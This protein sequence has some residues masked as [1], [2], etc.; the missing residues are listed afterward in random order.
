MMKYSGLTGWVPVVA[1]VLGL[2]VAAFASGGEGGLE[3]RVIWVMVGW[4][5]WGLSALLLEYMPAA[6]GG[7][8]GTRRWRKLGLGLIAL[9]I[10]SL[11]L[12]AVAVRGEDGPLDP[13]AMWGAVAVSW[14][15]VVGLFMVMGWS[16]ARDVKRK[17][18]GEL[19]GGQ[20][21]PGGNGL[22]Q[23]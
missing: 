13:R 15:A 2:M 22:G 3:E 7:V 1:M 4:G 23:G 14:M 21:E 19:A 9:T 10:G 6:F 20:P 12:L 16:L 11:M 17:R 8:S 5:A 18:A